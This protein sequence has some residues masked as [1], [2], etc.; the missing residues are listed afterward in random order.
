MATN[1]R[2]FL[3][4]A[5]VLA[6]GASG[7]MA[8]RS[9]WAGRPLRPAAMLRRM[10]AAKNTVGYASTGSV[11]DTLELADRGRLAVNG[12]LGS[13]DPAMDYEAHF[14]NFFDVHPAYMPI[15]PRW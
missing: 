10:I 8:G 5:A 13:L 4:R 12:V 2:A 3:K 1:R 14:L 7:A 9:N 11:P 6:A 15:G